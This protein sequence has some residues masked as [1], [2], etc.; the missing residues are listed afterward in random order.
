MSHP[1]TSKLNDRPAHLDELFDLMQPPRDGIGFISPTTQL[2]YK[3]PGYIS[4]YVEYDGTIEGLYFNGNE[5]I[6]DKPRTTHIHEFMYNEQFNTNFIG[7]HI[8][9]VGEKHETKIEAVDPMIQKQA[10]P[11]YQTKLCLFH[12]PLSAE[13][14]HMI[15]QIPQFADVTAIYGSPNDGIVGLV[16]RERDMESPDNDNIIFTYFRP[17]IGTWRILDT[18][19]VRATDF[20]IG[21]KLHY[22]TRDKLQEY[23]E[24]IDMIVGPSE[25]NN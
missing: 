11:G 8:D 19:G 23:Y 6:I 9:I 21:D 18:T 12:R 25:N 3:D 5:W 15:N 14:Y 4:A 2:P 13:D 7:K 24:E 1:A 20:E 22:E 16:I 17:D 10:P